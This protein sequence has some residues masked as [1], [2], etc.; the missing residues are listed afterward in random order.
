MPNDILK[1]RI[2]ERISIKWHRLFFVCMY[3]IWKKH[4]YSKC[5]P[6]CSLLML[7]IIHYFLFSIFIFIFP[8]TLLDLS[9][10]HLS[11]TLHLPS[12]KIKVKLLFYL[13]FQSQNFKSI[14]YSFHHLFSQPTSLWL[15]TLTHSTAKLHLL[16]SLSIFHRC[17][18][19]L[20]SLN[21]SRMFTPCAI[22]THHASFSFLVTSMQTLLPSPALWLSNLFF[23]FF[24]I[25]TYP[26]SS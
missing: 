2:T 6:F 16:R 5:N 26:L 17:L 7:L 10:P 11:L 8:P 4:N 9:H 12:L 22:A 24:A 20:I 21:L 18:W 14:I 19:V 15:T 1:E 3:N 23:F 25:D 13:H